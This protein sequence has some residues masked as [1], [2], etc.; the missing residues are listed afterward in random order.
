MK[1]TLKMNYLR[2][3]FVVSKK[4]AKFADISIAC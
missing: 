3:K 1:I 2:N 4:K